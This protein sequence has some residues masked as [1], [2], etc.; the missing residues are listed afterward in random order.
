MRLQNRK[1]VCAKFVPG[2]C[3]DCAKTSPHRH[4]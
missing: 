3:Q 1:N 4:R 2:M